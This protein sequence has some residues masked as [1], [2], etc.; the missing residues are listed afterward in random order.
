M[1]TADNNS[2][3]QDAFERLLK[4]QY[5]QRIQD[6]LHPAQAGLRGD[7]RVEYGEDMPPLQQ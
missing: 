7:V 2:G 6:T 1:P 3:V 5:S 4:Q